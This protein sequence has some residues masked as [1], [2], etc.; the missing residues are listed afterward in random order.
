MKNTLR[1]LGLVVIVIGVV[2]LAVGAVFIQQGFAKETFLKEAMTQEQITLTGVEGVI[3]TAEEAQVAGDT[4]RDHRHGISPTYGDLLGGENFDPTNLTQLSY[5]QALNLENYLYLAVASFG[6]FTIAKATG[7]FMIL[8][9]IG[10]GLI[11][12]A[13]WKKSRA[14]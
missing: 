14:A 10:L 3:D 11:G 13:I 2:A 7:A 12:F 4:V 5:A 9:G 6:M 8:T 1:N